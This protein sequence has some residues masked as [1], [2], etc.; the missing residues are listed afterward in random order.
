MKKK[1]DPSP[2]LFDWSEL[3]HPTDGK[4]AHEAARATDNKKETNRQIVWALFLQY[5]R[6]QEP[7]KRTRN[8]FEFRYLPS[9]LSLGLSKRRCASLRRRLSDITMVKNNLNPNLWLLA[10]LETEY[11]N[12][13]VLVLTDRGRAVRENPLIMAGLWNQ[14]IN[15][16][17]P[18]HD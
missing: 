12:S 3:V 6:D 16:N 7:M 4:T 8:D 18:Y 17:L 13:A 5:C 9:L 14:S 10:E 15:P 2:D 11:E 1:K